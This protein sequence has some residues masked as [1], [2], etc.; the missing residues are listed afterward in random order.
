MLTV[1]AS[2]RGYRASLSCHGKWNDVM[3]TLPLSRDPYEHRTLLRICERRVPTRVRSKQ[4]LNTSI[5]I[6]ITPE[7]VIGILLR[8]AM[9]FQQCGQ[10][11]QRNYFLKKT[12]KTASIP[13]SP[14]SIHSTAR[15]PSK[16][17]DALISPFFFLSFLVLC[18]KQRLHYAVRV[19]SEEVSEPSST[20]KKVWKEG[21]NRSEH[22]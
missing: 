20:K 13:Q 12:R 16:T 8:N 5:L 7:A 3:V 2:E 4:P 19:P 15:V 10:P 21:S 9:N 22:Q 1:Q 18:T 6:T 17:T 14:R 11:V